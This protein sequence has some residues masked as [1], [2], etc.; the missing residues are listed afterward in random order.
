MPRPVRVAGEEDALASVDAL[1]ISALIRA[2]DQ[3]ERTGVQELKELMLV[4][5]GGAA[6]K[7]LR[8]YVLH[9][10]HVRGG[11]RLLIRDLGQLLELLGR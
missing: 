6:I 11:W 2:A 9:A 8:H 7:P 10:E 4:P 5:G 3:C 1:A